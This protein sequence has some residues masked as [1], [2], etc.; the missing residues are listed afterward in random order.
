M[1]SPTRSGSAPQRRPWRVSRLALTP[2]GCPPQAFRW[3]RRFGSQ[4]PRGPASIL[5]PE[6]PRRAVSSDSEEQRPPAG[7]AHAALT[8]RGAR[9]QAA[10]R[11]AVERRAMA[12]DGV[13][14]AALGDEGSLQAHLRRRGAGGAGQPRG[15]AWLFRTLEAMLGVRPVACPPPLLAKLSNFPSGQSAPKWSK[16]SALRGTPWGE[17]PLP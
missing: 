6:S 2:E 11:R 10:A 8:A 1:R 7:A 14:D 4:E 16:R 12:W 17:G 15:E 9:A 5:N 3:S 13:A